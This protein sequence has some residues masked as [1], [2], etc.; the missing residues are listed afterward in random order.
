MRHIL[1]R[2][3]NA[4]SDLC[5]VKHFIS[6]R[7]RLSYNCFEYRAE[8][9]TRYFAHFV[10]MI[11]HSPGLLD[12]GVCVLS[13]SST[14]NLPSIEQHSSL[15]LSSGFLRFLLVFFLFYGMAAIVTP[16][17]MDPMSNLPLGMGDILKNIANEAPMSGLKSL[18][19]DHNKSFDNR[20][21][22]QLR[23]W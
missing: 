13:S 19:L 12:R 9:H 1:S 11:S 8:Y 16:Q 18:L 2:H 10:N 22:E 7:F 17:L 21:N 6:Y 15:L 5:R 4:N 23:M 3:H 14:T 20:M